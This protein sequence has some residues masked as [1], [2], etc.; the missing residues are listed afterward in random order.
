MAGKIV[1]RGVVQT[2]SS[3]RLSERGAPNLG[4]QSS[5]SRIHTIPILEHNENSDELEIKESY[6]VG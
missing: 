4:N 2:L 1:K 3:S 6:P 5:I